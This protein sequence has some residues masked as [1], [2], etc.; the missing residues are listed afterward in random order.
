MMNVEGRKEECPVRRYSRQS[1]G[2]GS[3]ATIGSRKAYEY[4]LD[5]RVIG[6]KDLETSLFLSLSL[7]SRNACVTRVG[8]TNFADYR[9]LHDFTIHSLKRRNRLR[10]DRATYHIIL[11]PL[12]ILLYSLVSSRKFYNFTVVFRVRA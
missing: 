6:R 12:W 4:T 7:S 3:R 2:Y 9:N 10:V 8:L 11:F 1:R 5:T